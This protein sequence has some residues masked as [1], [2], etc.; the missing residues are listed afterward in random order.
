MNEKPVY[1]S[2]YR[3]NKTAWHDQNQAV[4]VLA[5]TAAPEVPNGADWLKRVGNAKYENPTRKFKT[6]AEYVA[7]RRRDSG[8]R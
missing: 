7:H 2:V 6:D 3:R 1:V 5:F 8:A 4:F